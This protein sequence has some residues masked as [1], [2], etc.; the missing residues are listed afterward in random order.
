MN[1]LI[2]GTLGGKN[3][4]WYKFSEKITPWRRIKR[5]LAE[6]LPIN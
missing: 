2:L 1:N 6:P 5:L 4:P 3:L